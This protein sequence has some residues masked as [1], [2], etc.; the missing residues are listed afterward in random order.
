MRSKGLVFI[1]LLLLVA[2]GH[3]APPLLPEHLK[4][5]GFR[6]VG[7]LVRPGETI[8]KLDVSP[9]YVN[10]SKKVHWVFLTVKRCDA[11]CGDCE[12]VYQGRRRPGLLYIEDYPVTSITCYKVYGKTDR[13]VP[14]NRFVYIVM[15]ES[16]PSRVNLK[17]KAFGEDWVELYLKGKGNVA[18]YRRKGGRPY[19]YEPVSVV[20]VEG[21]R[22]WRDTHLAEGTLY[23]YSARSRRGDSVVLFE[24]F[25]SNEVCAKPLDIYPPPVPK[26]LSGIY[27][28]GRVY[29]TW[30]PVKAKDLKGYFVYRK[31]GNKWVRLNREPVAAPLYE[32]KG[33]FRE[34]RLIYAVSSVDMKGNES[35]KSQPAVIRRR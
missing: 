2:C 21:V 13:D 34:K 25:S 23:C 12:L 29:L 9:K 15:P 7:F 24:S 28:R 35:A 19:D 1:A 20:P 8:I 18:I 30:D 22:V 11:N 16:P 3:K 5:E 14:L 27:R 32:D 10:S 33:P 6:H 31:I 26:H 4:A 17:I